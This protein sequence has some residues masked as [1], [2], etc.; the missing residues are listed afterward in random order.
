[1]LTD[2]GAMRESWGS[3]RWLT[4]ISRSGLSVPAR[5]VV[6]DHQVVPGRSVLDY[7]CGRGDDVRALRDMRFEASGWDPHYFP[8]SRQAPADVV[9]M[10]YVL[11]VIE[12]PEE[13][14]RTLAQAWD[15]AQH[16]LVVSARLVWERNKV[17]GSHIAD[18]VLTSKGT[19]QHLFGSSELRDLVQEVTGAR[20]V[21]ATPGIVYAFRE[22]TARIAFLARRIVPEVEWLASADTASAIASVVDFTERRGRLPRLE[23]MP[24]VLSE[25]LANLRLSDLHR[26]IRRSADPE[27][28][29]AGLKRTALNTL[30][31]LAVELFNGRGPFGTLPLPIQLDIR[32]CF[33][34]Y[35][36]ACRRADRLLLKLR[37]DTY[38]R[39]AMRASAV[40]KLTPTALYVHRR[41]IDRMPT[42]LRLYEH[43]AA[44]AAGR[45]REWTLIK[46]KHQGRAVSWLHYPD[47]DADPHPRLRSSYS[48][49]MRDLETTYLSYE[50][51][52][53][54]PLLHRKHEF[55]APDDPD[56]PKYRRLTAA[57]VRAGLYERPHLI[58]TEDGWEAELERCAR[59][60]RGHR[61]LHRLTAAPPAGRPAPGER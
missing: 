42:V 46:L 11:N 47:F 7:G 19:F 27:K 61:L 16:V 29:T 5:Q 53:N 45:P 38:I 58:G 41:A 57:E 31:F 34:S 56:A 51:S 3:E 9:L 40:G 1:M 4:A 15:L 60:L 43:C 48:I 35:H 54:R 36:E 24:A 2:G 44:I 59:E 30:L 12:D 18:G 14:H 22:D 37:D 13:R 39:G 6:I 26:I 28:T 52:G 32:A 17:S 23:E 55:L 21:S 33:S 25:L 10:T 50:D 8:D 49:E 20:C